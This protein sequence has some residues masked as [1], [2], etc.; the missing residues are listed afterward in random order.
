MKK[1]QKIIPVILAGGL[2]TRL[3][4]LSSKNLPKQFLKILGEQTLLQDTMARFLALKPKELFILGNIDHHELLKKDLPV[5]QTKI[6]IILEPTQRNTAPSITIS[7]LMADPE[8]YLIVSPSDHYLPNSDTLIDKVRQA[9]EL[10]AHASIILFGIKPNYPSQSYGY[11]KK[12][13]KLENLYDVDSFIEKPDKKSAESYIQSQDYLWNSGIFLFKAQ[14]FLK[15]MKKFNPEMLNLCKQTLNNS[16]ISEESIKLAKENYKNLEK[17]SID[18]ALLEKT[19]SLKVLELET[20]WG[21]L[22]TWKSIKEYSS[23]DNNENTLIGD[24]KFKNLKRTYVNSDRKNIFISGLEDLLIVDRDNRLLISN[25]NT[26]NDFDDFL[27]GFT[28]SDDENFSF[29]PWGSFKTI[30]KDRNCHV[31]LLIVNV[32]GMLSL[33]KH[34]HRSEH[35]TITAGKARVVKG[36]DEIELTKDTSIKIEQGEVHRITNIGNEDLQIIEVQIGDYFGEDDIQRFEDIY[37]RN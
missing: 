5:S 4:P 2:G 20:D 29:R 25:A 7:A 34:E 15:E 9:D 13:K 16:D 14:D 27:D 10:T 21:D 32:G 11:I 23:K 37:D 18:Y 8:D 22:G 36:K 26:P 12:G 31:K 28:E 33:Q 17:I 19:K 30:M 24:I 6:S 1:N 3:W 35:W